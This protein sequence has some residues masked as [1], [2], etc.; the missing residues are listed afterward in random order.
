MRYERLVFDDIELKTIFDRLD[1]SESMFDLI[2]EPNLFSLL[3]YNGPIEFLNIEMI[4]KL[5]TDLKFN[6][7]F[8][9][10][11]SYFLRLFC[12][13]EDNFINPIINSNKSSYTTIVVLSG[14]IKLGMLSS[15]THE[16]ET[17][18]LGP[19]VAYTYPSDLFVSYAADDLTY[20][21]TMDH[22]SMFN[23]KDLCSIY[24]D[25]IS[26]LNNMDY[27]NTSLTVE[28]VEKTPFFLVSR[29]MKKLEE[30]FDSNAKMALFSQF[31]KE[32]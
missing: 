24:S 22:L 4:D 1:T 28:Q 11:N 12:F 6:S 27:E 21:C 7:L 20:F 26:A 18:I 13:K 25:L 16:P 23:D 31:K 3:R 10:V 15:D 19:G 5:E 17:K 29:A 14:T 8:L 30:R 32:A 2:T 9:P